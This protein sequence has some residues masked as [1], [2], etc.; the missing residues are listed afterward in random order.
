MMLD[1]NLLSQ[2]LSGRKIDA[3]LFKKECIE[4]QCD[5]RRLTLYAVSD[6]TFL[7]DDVHEQLSD[8]PLSQKLV[9]LIGRTISHVRHNAM[10][11]YCFLLE[12]FAVLRVHERGSLCG[13]TGIV[14]DA[15]G[16][17]MAF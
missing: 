14:S 9:R 8:G 12:D 5:D 17:S 7:P 3:V 15:A 1:D 16:A 6:V 11:G 2:K 4:I 13:E 10:E